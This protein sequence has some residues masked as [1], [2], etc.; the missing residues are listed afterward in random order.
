MIMRDQPKPPETFRLLRGDFLNPDKDA[1][2]LSPGVPGSVAG[3]IDIDFRN[4]L[5]LARW[6]VSPQNPLTARVTVNRVWLRFF[7]AG[8]VETENDF[9]Y[10]GTAPSHPELLNWLA[11][12]FIRREWSFKALHRVIVTSATYRQ[13]SAYREDLAEIDSAN[14]W[15]G[16]QS[17]VRVEAEIVR[18][19][20]LAASGSLAPQ[21]GGPSVH[22][23]QPDGVYSFTQTP[24]AWPENKDSGRYRRTMYTEFFR[25]LRTRFSRRSTLPTSARSARAGSA[26]TR[27]CRP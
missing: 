21:L 5:D 2:P 27:R 16:R 6:L 22:P 17:R 24:K 9:G 15:L 11:S 8:L 1:G 14:R 4:R 19:M 25:T 18:D 3:G 26:P 7:G 23:P 20:V 10:Q 12:E 13:S